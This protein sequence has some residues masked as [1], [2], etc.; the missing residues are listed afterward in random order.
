MGF[1]AFCLPVTLLIPLN[2]KINSFCPHGSFKVSLAFGILPIACSVQGASCWIGWSRFRICS[3]VSFHSDGRLKV[4]CLKY[5]LGMV[6]DKHAELPLSV[7]RSLFLHFCLQGPGHTCQA[8]HTPTL[9]L[10]VTGPLFLHF[11][12]APDTHASPDPQSR[13]S[14]SPGHSF[15]ISFLSVFTSTSFSWFLLC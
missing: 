7:S 5:V 3:L 11:F 10:S 2:L 6:L 12:K 8:P 9:T 13:P 1:A 15:F 4:P 14:L